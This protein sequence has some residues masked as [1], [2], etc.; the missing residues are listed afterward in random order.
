MLNTNTRY[1]HETARRLRRAPRARCC[2]PR[3][4][5]VL[6]R[7]LRER[8]QRA[9]AAPGPRLHAR[10]AR[11]RRRWRRLPRQHPGAHRRQPLQVR[12]PG[13]RRARRRGCTSRRCPT[14]YRGRVRRDDPE[15]GRKYARAASG[16]AAPSW[17]RTAAGPRRSSRVAPRRAA[18][19][20]CCRRATSRRRTAH[21]RAA[22]G[23]CI[24]D[25]VQVGFGRVGTPLL[26]LRDPGRRAGHRHAGQA[27]RERPPARRG[28]D[29]AGDRRARSP[30]GWSTSTPSAATRVG[31][32]VGLAVLDVIAR[33][34]AA[35]A[36]A[37]GGRA[38]ARGPVGALARHPV[39]GDVRG[40]GLFLGSGARQRPGDARAGAAPAAD[41]VVNGCGSAG[42]CS[43]TDGP[44]TTSSRSS[45]RCRSRPRTPTCWLPSWPRRSQR[46]ARRRNKEAKSRS[47][48]HGSRLRAQARRSEP[49]SLRPR[50][51]PRP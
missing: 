1:L 20:S 5:R 34:A 11:R 29:H 41:H 39:V 27:D 22:G 13:R 8:G 42:S 26:G 6:L 37:Q 14:T 4:R 21:V 49:G 30:T 33:R 18:G 48:L 38:P 36:R 46:T 47:R 3:C 16:D 15:A 23:V 12:R 25:E 10:P 51:R 40:L 32:R 2:R 35:G 7:E 50:P 24:A 9:R 28:R 43:S 17:R 31:A 45:R 44:T 19:R